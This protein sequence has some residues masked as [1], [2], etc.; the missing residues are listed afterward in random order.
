MKMRLKKN[1]VDDL[2]I[3]K[4]C[5]HHAHLDEKNDADFLEAII[6]NRPRNLKRILEMASRWKWTTVLHGLYF[7][8]AALIAQVAK[9]VLF[10]CAR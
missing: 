7:Y 3:V 8:I 1:R 2:N 4:V 5:E 10:K 9:P 6:H